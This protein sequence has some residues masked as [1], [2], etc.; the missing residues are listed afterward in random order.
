MKKLF[1]DF[2][3]KVKKGPAL[4][5]L[6]DAWWRPV[7]RQSRPTWSTPGGLNSIWRQASEAR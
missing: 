3:D 6:D 2:N 7:E 4:L 1:V 5:E